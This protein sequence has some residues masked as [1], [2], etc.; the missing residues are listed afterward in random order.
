MAE[1]SS[2]CFS[3]DQDTKAFW[4]DRLVRE[5]VYAYLALLNDQRLMHICTRG[6]VKVNAI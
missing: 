2:V 6:T 1:V 3:V 5:C 4:E